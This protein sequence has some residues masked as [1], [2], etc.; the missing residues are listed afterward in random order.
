MW[1]GINYLLRMASDLDYLADYK[2]ITDWLGFPII[3]NPCCVPFA[4]EEGTHLFTD[5]LM[6][7]D[8]KDA[9]ESSTASPVDGFSVGGTSS[10]KLRSKF[11]SAKQAARGGS[12]DGAAGSPYRTRGQDISQSRSGTGSIV[13]SPMPKG[14]VQSY[15]PNNEMVRIRNA[16]KVI[17]EEEAKYGRLA[18]DP[19]GRVVPEE[20]VC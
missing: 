15:V 10:A 9:L 2:A 19:R 11:P 14:T 4:M 5:S 17:M 13:G 8:G 16:E 12:K 7:T 18:R 6:Q 1:N 3:R 20:Q